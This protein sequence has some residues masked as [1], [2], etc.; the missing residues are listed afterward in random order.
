MQGR[1]EG[2]ELNQ[3]CLWLY[4]ESFD[5][6]LR[7][8]TKPNY[9]DVRTCTAIFMGAVGFVCAHKEIVVGTLL[10]SQRFKCLITTAIVK[11]DL[12]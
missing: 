2:L 9:D 10:K 3:P 12:S 5:F 1:L 8:C 11:D 4:K 7:I 6:I